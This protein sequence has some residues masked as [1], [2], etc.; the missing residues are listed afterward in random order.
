MR[1]AIG[2]PSSRTNPRAAESRLTGD[3]FA[4]PTQAT[5]ASPAALR[6]HYELGGRRHGLV[7]DDFT[8]AGRLP[9]GAQTLQAG[10]CPE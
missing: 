2:A 8:D 10:P 1:S 3:E 9:D 5:N 6:L 7:D 4:S